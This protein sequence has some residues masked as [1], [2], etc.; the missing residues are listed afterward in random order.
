MNVTEAIALA[1]DFIPD[2]FELNLLAEFKDE[3]WFD[4]RRSDGEML[5]GA[6]LVIVDKATCEVR[7][8]SIAEDFPRTL[9]AWNGAEKMKVSEIDK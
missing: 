1:R 2:Q 9:Q 6:S 4:Y 8:K 3:Y 5:I 7:M